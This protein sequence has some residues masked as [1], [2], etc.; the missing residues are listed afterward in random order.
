M[1]PRQAKME[2]LSFQRKSPWGSVLGSQ[3]NREAPRSGSP[4]SVEAGS[5]A[6][7]CGSC[8]SC[9]VSKVPGLRPW[10]HPLTRTHSGPEGPVRSPQ[11]R[12]PGCR[13]PRLLAGACRGTEGDGWSPHRALVIPAPASVHRPSFRRALEQGPSV[14][15]PRGPAR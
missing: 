10:G 3:K 6:P 13:M 9:R 1:T 8:M 5:V 4:T 2:L 15:N 7:T 11:T 14:L 12:Q